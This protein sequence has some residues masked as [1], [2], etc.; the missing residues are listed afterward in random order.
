MIIFPNC[1]INLGLSVI[2]RRHDG[3]HNIQTV[4]YPLPLYDVLEIIDA[5]DGLFEF[6]STGIDTGSAENNLCVKAYHLLQKDFP[7]PK[8]KMH[9][10]KILPVGAGLGGGSADGTFT[11][12]LLNKKYSLGISEKKLHGYALQLG[13]DCPFFILN[14]PCIANGRGE[15]MEPVDL[16]LKGFFLKLVFPGISISTKD[17]FEKVQMNPEDMLPDAIISHPIPFWKN[18]LK[19]AFEGVVFGLHPELLDIKNRLYNEGAIYA[20][21]SGTGSTIYGIFSE[22]QTNFPLNK[23]EKWLAL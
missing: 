13:S 2:N 14:K 15:L 18:H 1:K 17:L 5:Q 20:A 10:H 9:L 21:M 8:I 23:N 11:L 12:L 7:I 6:I 22:K 19:N 16:S 4:F 3:Y